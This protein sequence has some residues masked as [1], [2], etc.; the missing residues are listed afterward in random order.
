MKVLIVD[1]EV[2]V[3]K[4][5]AL[6]VDFGALG[7]EEIFE[8]SNGLEALEIV[9]KEKPDL[10]FTDIKMPKMNGIE[11]ID[12]VKAMYPDTVILVLSCM[13]DS[14][15]IREALKFNRALDYIMKMTMTSDELIPI[16]LKAIHYIPDSS[17]KTAQ[18]KV[19][20]SIV[21]ADEFKRL[22]NAIDDY[23]QEDM[24]EIIEMIFDRA[25]LLRISKEQFVEWIQLFGLFSTKLKELDLDL[26]QLEMNH[27]HVYDYL[28]QA[29]NLDDLKTRF[30]AFIKIYY[31]SIKM[32]KGIYLGVE[33]RQ[34][35]IMVRKNYAANLKLG[36]LAQDIG[37]NE[38]YLSRLFKK[39]MG[40]NFSDYLNQV[41]LS[42]AKKMILNQE[43]PLYEIAEY[44]GYNSESYFSRIFKQY[45][46][47]TPKQ[48]MDQHRKVQ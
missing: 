35:L 14:H 12:A 28:A 15:Y 1:D 21:T 31:A 23:A 4:G 17:K 19:Y 45:E 18:D 29:T 26:D 8:A 27:Q 46:G 22:R 5:L 20:K 13:N 39:Q 33:V 16:L 11:L 25:L 30:V 43:Y 2:L 47:V 38:S 36:D 7:F 10:I 3:R 41:R 24:I 40:M 34:V 32:S 37:L 6:S 9:K 42:E 48:F 44:V